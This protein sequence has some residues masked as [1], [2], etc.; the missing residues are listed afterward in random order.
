ML[1]IPKPFSVVTT[2]QKLLALGEEV[3]CQDGEFVVEQV[4][5]LRDSDRIDG[6]LHA[7]AQWCLKAVMWHRRL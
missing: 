4:G 2:S 3:R 6:A 7:C 1:E 5:G